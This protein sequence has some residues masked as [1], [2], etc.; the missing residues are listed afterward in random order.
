MYSSGASTAT[1]STGSC[2]LPSTSLV[3]TSGLPTVSSKPSRRMISI[4]TASWSSPRPCTSHAVGAVVGKH[5]E[6]DV[7]D[8]LLVEARLH[9]AGGEL[10][11]FGAG[12]RRR[13]DPERHRERRLVD[14]GHGQ[15]ARILEVGDRLADRHL[16]EAGDRDDLARPGLVGGHALE[17]LRDEEL[18]D[19]GALD[20]PVGAA[21]GDLLALAQRRRGGS[22][23]SASRPTY[24]DAS[25]LVTS[26]C[27]GCSGS[28]DGRRRSSSSSVSKSGRGPRRARRARARPCRPA[29]CSRRSGTRSGARPRRGR[30]RAR[31]PRRSPPARARRGGRPC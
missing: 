29:R 22:R 7:A 6:R 19:L 23:Q 13:V 18:R 31:T 27:S 26:A 9:L 16:G 2:T 17:R 21:P 12:Q 5:A 8:E 4:R 3:S 14:D 20:R 10:V 15:R 25:R 24:G 28:Y 1:R 11:P 30:G